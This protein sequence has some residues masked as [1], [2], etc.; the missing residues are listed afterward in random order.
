MGTQL[1][2]DVGRKLT[3]SK[4]QPARALGLVATS[5]AFLEPKQLLA[6]FFTSSKVG[7]GTCDNQLRYQAIN[8]ALAAT[9]CIPAE[10][11]LGN[12]VREVLGVVASEI[13]PAFERVLVT[14]KPVLKEISGKIPTRNEVVH[15]I[16]NY[17][18]VK[19]SA[20]RVRSLGAMVVEVTEQ[21]AL[22][23]SLRVLSQ[24]LLRTKAEEQRRIAQEL[25]ASIVQYHAAL[26]TS[27]RCLVRPIWQSQDRAELLA[28]AVTLLEHFPVV[29]LKGPTTARNIF[30][31]LGRDPRLRNGF[32]ARIAG[33]PGL[34][35]EMLQVLAQ[36]PEA[37][38][39]LI[40]QMARSLKFRGWLL[41]VAAQQLR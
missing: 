19:D 2:A 32:F 8:R 27:L 33:D 25:H 7:F 41:K 20:G 34:Q 38:N 1:K 14:R 23:E 15:W 9:N 31:Q 13:E 29:P 35:R 37:Q 4:D 36:H 17:F 6:P 30:Q 11:H 39:G 22:Q 12:T 24:E 40:L 5:E 3:R 28:Q 26:K 21:K 10:A 18:P 16:A